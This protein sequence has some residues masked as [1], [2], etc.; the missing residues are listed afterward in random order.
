MTY[1]SILLFAI[2]GWWTFRAQQYKNFKRFLKEGDP[3]IYKKKV[4]IVYEVE[5]G[6]WIHTQNDT[7]EVTWDDIKPL[8]FFN[9][10]E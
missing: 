2:A 6:M 10:S 8:F 9:Y 7:I 3:V 1:I 4:T 5:I